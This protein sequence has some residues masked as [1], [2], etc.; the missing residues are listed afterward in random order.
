MKAEKYKWWYTYG[1]FDHGENNLPHLGQVIRYYR[2]LRQQKLTHL[3]P[4]KT[5]S[6]E[7]ESELTRPSRAYCTQRKPRR[8]R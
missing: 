5:A 3:L 1:P 4:S 8:R 2:E 7:K 6:Y